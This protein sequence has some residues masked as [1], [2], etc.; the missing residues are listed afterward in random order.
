MYQLGRAFSAVTI[1]EGT[2]HVA[3]HH[4]LQVIHLE[5]RLRIAWELDV[6]AL[7][8]RHPA[9]MLW[10]TRVYSFIHIPGTILFL[11]WLYYYTNTQNRVLS[12]NSNSAHG[13]P[14][15]PLL[16]EARRRTMALCNILAFIVFTAWPC[17]P[18]RLLSDPA[19]QGKDVVEASKYAFVDTVH[20]KNGEASVWTENRFVNHYAAMPS[21]H[22]GYS[23]LVGLTIATI[24]LAARHRR[25]PSV[26]MP[27]LG[28][29]SCPSLSRF[30]CILIGFGYSFIILTAIVATANHFILD[31]VAGAIIC[32]IAW[33]GNRVLLNLVPL[34]DCFLWC[35]RIHK[36]ERRIVEKG[37]LQEDLC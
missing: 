4:A 29:L 36:P 17:M 22:F 34:E 33:N 3:R 31:A 9:L 30:F 19:S 6:Q 10:T 21:L 13:S 26:W 5:E 12:R 15:G 27:L 14:A 18:P 7:F 37:V 16:Y 35:V 23:L 20:A 11:V 1:V 28:R 25:S 32:G 24:P 2:V 8:L